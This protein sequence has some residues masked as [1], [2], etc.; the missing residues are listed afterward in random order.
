LSAFSILATRLAD[1]FEVLD[2]PIIGDEVPTVKDFSGRAKDAPSDLT[3]ALETAGTKITEAFEVTR[4]TVAIFVLIA[5][6]VLNITQ[7][8][9]DASK[10]VMGEI[11]TKAK[12]TSEV[13]DMV[14]NIETNL[15][16]A[17]KKA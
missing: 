1:L 6:E 2:D 10:K 11:A 14:T 16:A 13:K 17:L 8:T 7:I 15:K 5:R 9:W 4:D 12:Q 3:P